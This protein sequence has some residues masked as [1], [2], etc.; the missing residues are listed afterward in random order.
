MKFLLAL[1]LAV[2]TLATPVISYA[3]APATGAPSPKSALYHVVYL[4]YNG[5]GKGVNPSSP[6]PL[7]SADVWNIPAGCVLTRVY[8]IIDDAIVGPTVGTFNVG[9]GDGATTWITGSSSVS[10]AS[11]GMKGNSSQT[12]K[13]YLTA[14]LLKIALTGAAT[15]GRA[16]LVVEGYYVGTNPS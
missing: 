6:L 7:S 1:M 8:L 9:D 15:A 11:A 5:A 12:A 10:P 2:A 4:R 16:R 14:G 3:A 13:Y